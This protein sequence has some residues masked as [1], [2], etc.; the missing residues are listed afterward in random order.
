MILSDIKTK[1]GRRAG[2]PQLETYS[3]VVQDYF[4]QAFTT[5][6][7]KPK[8][9]KD[10]TPFYEDE[11]I[12]LLEHKDVDVTTDAL[13]GDINLSTIEHLL[14]A[15]NVTSS[16]KPTVFANFKLVSYS[17]INDIYMNPTLTPSQKEGYWAKQGNRIRVYFQI[18]AKKPVVQI[19]IVKNPDT[20]GW[21]ANTDFSDFGLGFVYDCIDLASLL[22][23]KQIGLSE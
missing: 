16:Y 15:Y 20:S 8:S 19:A 17:E 1:I 11:I 22:L 9:D 3:G 12:P 4:E 5:L 18:G 10:P 7:K 14:Y 13:L 23:R 21:D 6:L 2:D